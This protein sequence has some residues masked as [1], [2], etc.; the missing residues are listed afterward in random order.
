MAGIIKVLP[1][2][3]ANQ[4]AAG[5]VIQRPASVVKELVENAIDA[6]AKSIQ[7]DIREAGRSLIQVIDDGKGMD[8]T[9]ARLA[10][11]RHATSKISTAEDLFAL[12]TMGFRGE[13]LASIASVAEV[14][15]RTR[16]ADDELGVE[17][18][19]NGSVVASQEPV[20]CS[21]G[22]SFAVKNLFFNIPVRRKF[23]KSNA[24]EFKHIVTE[25]QRVALAFPD[26]EFTLSQ[27]NTEIYYLPSTH[28]R[29]RIVHLFGKSINQQLVDVHTDTTLVKVSGFIGKPEFARK[30][31]GEQY[32][33]VNGRYMKH[34]FFHRTVCEAFARLLPPDAM[35]VY[36][37]YFDVDP[38]CI[39]VNIHPTKTEIK[40]ENEQAIRQILQS[41]VRESL[42]RF[43]I[44]PSLDFNTEPAIQI[45]VLS[46]STEFYVPQI[47]V[48]PDFNPFDE[49]APAKKGGASRYDMPEG[50]KQTD[51]VPDYF[52]A[53]RFASSEQ[54]LQNED[55]EEKPISQPLDLE[56]KAAMP[57][58]TQFKQKYLLTQ[59]KS[60]L[61]I[62]DQKR[63]HER[64]LF[65]QFAN[66]L[67]GHRS[68]AQV[69][70][71]P[72]RIDLSP[73][74]YVFLKEHLPEINSLGF[75]I[76]DFGNNS[77]VINALPAAICNSEPV[78]VLTGLLRELK[79][80]E[81]I[82]SG[83][84]EQLALSLA[85]A[86]AIPSG[87]ALNEQ[88]LHD[89]FNRLFATSNPNYTPD[90]KIIV[91]ILPIDEIEKRFR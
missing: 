53:Q 73:A 32:F 77:L 71:F 21:V 49:Q 85:K 12:R 31:A 87:K 57:G 60:G 14:C 39:D 3:I 23:L 6:G 15:L 4:I 45:P 36:F 80:S 25:F 91:S 69:S 41:A 46:P 67:E 63:A 54:M 56:T 34:Y 83:F 86:A 75:D 89:I 42:G 61:M 30:S 17:I 58:I 70:L 27:N 84:V 38:G 29:Q 78:Q 82:A 26:V 28:L 65:E 59:V 44:I 9:D 76:A 81:N 64:I 8:E 5:E 11:E 7:V 2:S 24:T 18:N 33:F 79:L 72:Q 22:S 13:A 35:P 43:N 52:A 16:K 62:I 1:D 20:Q 68:P 51:F 50:F 74:D 47:E 48:N 19:I 10:F 37:L 66:L 40:F 55:I 90:G 88:E